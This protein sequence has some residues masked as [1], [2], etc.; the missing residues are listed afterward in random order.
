MTYKLIT[1]MNM[2]QGLHIPI[3]YVNEITGGLFLRLLL[4]AI[5]CIVTF[6]IYFSQ[7]RATGSGDFPVSVAVSGFVT[8]V[9]TIIMLL[10]TPQIVD[11]LTATV[12]F[13]IATFSVLW[14]LF[15]KSTE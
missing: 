6:G 12:V 11:T 3:V 13:V 2:S 7:K 14:L 8:A 15:S 1:E 4:L 9:F 5:W 10:V